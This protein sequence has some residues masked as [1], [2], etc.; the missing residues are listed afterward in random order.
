MVT[1][2]WVYKM[3]SAL[4][5]FKRQSKG[6]QRLNTAGQYERVRKANQ[7]P[8][9]DYIRHNP[10]Q[11][12]WWTNGI[13]QLFVI[14]CPGPEWILG[15]SKSFKSKMKINNS[16]NSNPAFGKLWWTDGINEIKAI[17]PP[18]PQY[19]RGRSPSIK[20]TIKSKIGV[21]NYKGSNNP[22]SGL[23]W[24]TNGIDTVRA[25]ECPH[26][27]WVRGTGSIHRSKCSNNK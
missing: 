15:R 20:S 21:R 27:G 9:P 2:I 23:Y 1:G 14:N 11:H 24:W 5:A 19:Y 8:N 16:G 13:N 25:R 17:E 3:E 26:D 4:A 10:V 6:Q 12:K 7:F 22:A 18:G